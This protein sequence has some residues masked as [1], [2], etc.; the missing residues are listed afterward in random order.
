MSTTPKQQARKVIAVLVA[1]NVP[2]TELE[3]AVANITG[4]VQAVV[5]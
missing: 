2:P 1:Y 4:Q 5:V 3:Q